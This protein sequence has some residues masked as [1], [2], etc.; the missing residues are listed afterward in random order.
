MICS[1]ELVWQ[2][3]LST[4]EAHFFADISTVYH[5]IVK[6]QHLMVVI[7]KMDEFIGQ[8]IG[9]APSLHICVEVIRPLLKYCIYCER[10]KERAWPKLTMLCASW[11]SPCTQDFAG[12]LYETEGIFRLCL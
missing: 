6:C 11:Y 7:V 8:H 12:A 2:T 5:T 9:K 10:P 3:R 1:A 4:L